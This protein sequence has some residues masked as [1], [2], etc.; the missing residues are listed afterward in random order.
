MNNIEKEAKQHIGYSHA[1]EHCLGQ[2][3][4][5]LVVEPNQMDTEAGLFQHSLADVGL[6]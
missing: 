3:D 1:L 6:L 5:V 2:P 4:T